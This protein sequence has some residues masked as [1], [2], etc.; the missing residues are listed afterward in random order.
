MTIRVASLRTTLSS[1]LLLRSSLSPP[2]IQ[3]RTAVFGCSSSLRTQFL[4]QNLSSRP[5]KYSGGRMHYCAQLGTGEHLNWIFVSCLSSFVMSNLVDLSVILQFLRNMNCHFQILELWI[6]PV[7]LKVKI[8]LQRR[9]PLL[10]SWRT[11]RSSLIAWRHSS[12]TVTVCCCLFSCAL[13]YLLMCS[14][15]FLLVLA[16][17]EEFH[18]SLINSSRVLIN[19]Q[20]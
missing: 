10:P 5:K 12:S 2:C 11:M 3:Q 7:I 16:I 13:D 6:L 4:K 9:L 8:L 1:S 17:A 15:G 20:C 18:K 14:V 19:S